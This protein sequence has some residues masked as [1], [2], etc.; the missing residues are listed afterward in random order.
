MA[1]TT[2]ILEAGATAAQ[3]VGLTD[4]KAAWLVGW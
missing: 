2:D 1:A 4:K 3:L